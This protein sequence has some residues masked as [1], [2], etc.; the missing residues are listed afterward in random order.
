MGDR[1]TFAEGTGNLSRI[2]SRN[3]EDT[4]GSSRK[5]NRANDDEVALRLA[6]LEKLPTHKRVRRAIV[7]SVTYGNDD[8]D[9]GK[10]EHKE[11]DVRKLNRTDR[12]EFIDRLFKIP[13]DDND[14][15]LRN[16]RR[17]I[18]KVGIELPTVEVR[19]ENLTVDAHCFIGDRTLPTLSNAALNVAEAALSWFGFKSGK[20]AKLTILKDATGIIKPARMALLLGP[21]SSGKTT[22]LL[23]L[24][25]KLDSNLKQTA[26]Q[27]I[28]SSLITDYTLRCKQ[29][30]SMKD[31]EQYWEDKTQPYKYI[32]VSEF[33]SQFKRFHVGLRLEN[34]LSIPYD[35]STSH[36]AALVFNK[37][38][39][40]KVEILKATYDKEWLLIRRN[41]FFYVFKM[42]QIIIMAVITATVFLSKKMKADNEADGAVYIGSISFAVLIN[43]FNGFAELSLTIQRLPVFYKQRD[44]LF[45]PPWAFTLPIFLLSLPISVL[46]STAY[47]GVTYYAIGYAPEASRFFTQLLLIFLIQQMA[48]SLF[49]LICGVCRT[50]FVSNTGGGLTLLVLILFGFILPKD[51]V[52][53]W[54]EWAYWISPI[55]YTT[56][57]LAVNEMLAPRWMNKLASD[58]NTSLGVAVLKSFNFSIDPNWVWICA[59]ALFGFIILFNILFTFALTYLS[60]PETRQATTSRE[61]E[62]AITKSPGS[63]SA[64]IE[65]DSLRGFEFTS[66]GGTPKEM[67]NQQKSNQSNYNKPDMTDYASLAT[68]AAGIGPKRGMVLPFTPL[69]MSFD[70]VN[71]FVDV[72]PQ[73]KEQVD[74]DKLQLLS[75]VTGAFK[76]GILTALMG[77]SGAGKTT[78]MDVLSGR[79]TGGHIEGDIRISG[80]PKKQE[81]FARVTG[82][83]EQN[84]IHSPQ[85]T[86]RESL[87]YSAFLR[88]SRDIHTEDKMTFV[89]EVISLVE[90]DNLKDSIVGLPG[91]SGLSTEQRKRLTI[92]VE[93]VANPSIIFMDEPTS[94]LDARAAAIVMRTVRNTVDTGR[95]VLLLLKCG[96]QV[97]Y[98]GPLGRNSHILVEYFEVFLPSPEL[99]ERSNE[100]Y[101]IIGAMRIP[102]YWMWYYYICPMAWT[103][104]GLIV[105]QFGDVED[106]I[107][108]PGVTPDPSIKAYMEVQFGYDPDFMVPVGT[109]IVGFTVFF[110]FMYALCLRTLNFQTR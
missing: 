70:A 33:A 46:E 29:V 25:G 41:S 72:P 64:R 34:D 75:Q 18:D 32:S 6:V 66:D 89:D 30:T 38:L 107:E 102:V 20:K 76:P 97:I 59:A 84:D 49:R 43:I 100:L 96:G 57:S 99:W 10:V 90:L 74:H 79:K 83:C 11:I 105:S 95:T 26:I 42:V 78:L 58:N 77:V 8:K 4:F 12:K 37:Y 60:S 44:L 85:V 55:P 103:V 92:A 63:R 71:Y 53:S 45:H 15:F 94:G 47:T 110:A 98:S 23:A 5:W 40:S 80:Y 65:S 54:L 50:K 24:A 19:F 17:R 27:G 22:F 31:Q 93:L 87:I 73:M 7:T 3:M 52:P 28:Q 56:S 21:P 13:K 36:G 16:F 14:K 86:V 62:N 67:A 2:I 68:A 48:N 109:I 35:K 104:Y 1:E 39:D 101:T 106:T 82:Y 69:A 91:V 108:V 9:N 61:T 51:D 88:L 81:T